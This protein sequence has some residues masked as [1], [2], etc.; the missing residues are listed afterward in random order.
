MMMIHKH[1]C[2][3]HIRFRFTDVPDTPVNINVTDLTS[4]NLTL[5][6]T[7]PTDNNA[8]ILGYRVFYT[9]P[10]FLGGDVNLTIDGAEEELFVDDLHPGVTYE[11]LILA[12]NK[13]GNGNYSDPITIATLEE[14]RR[15]FL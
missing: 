12:F 11:F 13:K 8:L 3:L 6:W 10:S 14:G 15:N 7:E 1:L 2:L 9:R 5:T 4:R